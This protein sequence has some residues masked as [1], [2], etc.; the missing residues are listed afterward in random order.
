MYRFSTF[1]INVRLKLIISPRHGDSW[2]IDF[3]NKIR[4]AGVV[5]RHFFH[6][7]VAF[8]SGAHLE[9]DV[10]RALLLF[11]EFDIGVVKYNDR[12]QRC[13]STR[14]LIVFVHPH[15]LQTN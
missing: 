12:W 10:T 1:S 8:F 7:Y 4:R 2:P 13:L 11:Q 14:A 6:R 3:S 9:N 15:G 5:G